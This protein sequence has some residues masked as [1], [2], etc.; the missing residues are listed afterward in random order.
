MRNNRTP[1]TSDV[2][3]QETHTSLLQTAELIL[4]F[5]QELVDLR[6]RLLK[7]RKLDHRIR[8]LA[9]PKGVQ[10][11]VQSTNALLPDDLCPSLP[12]RMRKRRQRSLHADLDSL[13]GTQG[14]IS[15]ELGGR[16]GGKEDDLFRG[17]GREPLAVEVLEDLVE[18]VFACALHAVADEGWCPAEEHAAQTFFGVDHLPGLRVGLVEGG[19]DLAAAFHLENGVLAV[20][21]LEILTP[22]SFVDLANSAL[23]RDS[24]A[25]KTHQIQWR[26][27]S[28]RRPTRDNT[29]NR[30][31]RKVGARKQLNLPLRL[32]RVHLVRHCLLMSFSCS[33]RVLG[34]R[35]ALYNSLSSLVAC[36][37]DTGRNKG[38]SGQDVR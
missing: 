27:H 8:D 37:Q 15:E 18:A 36:C 12:Q 13:H 31:R 35:S 10:A 23:S 30:T 25:I 22:Q 16:G 7:R 6:N 38:A 2:T 33:Y 17:A 32:H 28:M 34:R 19:V 11:L 26:N 9:C 3:S 24:V 14:E 5:A 20:L 29:T 21:F 1:N 4:W